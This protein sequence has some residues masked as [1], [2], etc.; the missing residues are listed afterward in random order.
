VKVCRKDHEYRGDENARARKGWCP[1]C[2]RETQRRY[3][4]SDK[5]RSRAAAYEQSHKGMARRDRYLQSPAGWRQRLVDRRNH[6]LTRRKQRK[7]AEDS[8]G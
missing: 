2:F 1:V 4:Q 5:G 3:E 6:A 7:E 8:N